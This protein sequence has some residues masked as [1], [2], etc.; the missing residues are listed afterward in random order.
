M[1]NRGRRIFSSQPVAGTVLNSRPPHTRQWGQ[2]KFISKLPD[3][4]VLLRGRSSASA[5]VVAG[6][7][8]QTCRRGLRPRFGGRGHFSPRKLAAAHSTRPRNHLIG[9]HSLVAL[10]VPFLRQFRSA[11][12]AIHAEGSSAL[13]IIRALPPATIRA[14]CVRRHAVGKSGF[15]KLAMESVNI[16]PS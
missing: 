8:R 1:K 7:G 16:A 15:A 6:G 2:N 5:R 4:T 10:R 14:S 9:G 11:L 13:A 3:R 12:R